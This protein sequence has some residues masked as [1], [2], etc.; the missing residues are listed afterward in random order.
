MTTHIISINLPQSSFAKMATTNTNANQKP[1]A[2]QR[3]LSQVKELITSC[4]LTDSTGQGPEYVAGAPF[5]L[6]L[7]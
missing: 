4:K 2:V 7:T 1:A 6:S 3:S 5:K